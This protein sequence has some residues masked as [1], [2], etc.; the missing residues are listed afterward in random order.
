MRE[1]NERVFFFIEGTPRAPSW[2]K[3]DPPHVVRVFRPCLAV[4]TPLPDGEQARFTACLARNMQW[5]RESMGTMPVLLEEFGPPPGREV[6]EAALSLYYDAADA[7]LFHAALCGRTAAWKRPYPMATA[8]EPVS[9]SRD[10]HGVF[11]YRFRAEG[12]IAAPTVLYLPFDQPPHI[13]ATL[14]CEYQAETQRLLVYN[15]GYHGETEIGIS[16]AVSSVA[17]S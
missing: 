3:D 16:P 5:A 10:Q 7:G 1:V 9:I 2:G 11:R 8:G 17:V 12:G 4:D 15:D 6:D 13:T 14:R